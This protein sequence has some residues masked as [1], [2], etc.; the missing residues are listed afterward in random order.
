MVASDGGR[1]LPLD[2]S[3]GSKQQQN[4]YLLTQYTVLNGKEKDRLWPATPGWGR[5]FKL[6]DI[7]SLRSKFI[8]LCWDIIQDN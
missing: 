2:P 1:E 3:E 4:K 7:N 5:C 8:H 6:E